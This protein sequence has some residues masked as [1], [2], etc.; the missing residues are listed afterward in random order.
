VKIAVISDTHIA[1]SSKAAPDAM[2]EMVELADCVVHLGDF[3][4]EEFAD[5][6]EKRSRLYAVHGN[7]DSYA[8][9]S[10]YPATLIMELEG[11]KAALVH[12]FAGPWSAATGRAENYRRAGVSLILF[13]HTHKPEDTTIAGVRL[14]NPGSAGDGRQTKGVLTAGM[15]TVAGGRL[16]WELWPLG[17]EVMV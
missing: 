9:K 11:V 14:V 2:W 4:S 13:G 15:L 6:L 3:T 1:D 12:Q 10:R 7:A 5:E 16:S 17:R 8:L